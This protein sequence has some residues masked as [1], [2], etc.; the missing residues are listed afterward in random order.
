MPELP[1][2]ETVRRGLQHGVQGARIAAVSVYDRRLR[3][4][5][6]A[7]FEAA[8]IGATVQD[9]ERRS[10]YLLFRLDSGRTWL[11]HLGM[12]GSFVL[13]RGPARPARR[14]HDHV[15]VTLHT[16]EGLA[17][18]RYNDPRRFGSMHVFDGRDDAQPLLA[19]LGPEPLTDAFN[20]DY[21]HAATRRR[22][23]PI[24]QALMDNRLVVGVGNIY[25]NESLFRAGIHP[26][27]A[28][29]RV[30]RERL[31]RLVLE[32]KA[33]LHEAIAAGGSTLRDFVNSA[34]E[35]GYFQLDYN[36]YGRDGQPC[37]RCGRPLKPMR[38]GGRATVYCAHCQR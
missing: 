7:D 13:H 25:A 26:D 21:L 11:A 19:A 31:A 18:L 33:V 6:A 24:K 34:G 2:V 12:T 5:V 29:N 22:S 30:S 23:G 36:V 20:A 27:R 9:I 17:L 10:K 8:L 38:H 16:P 37:R 15:D 28:V 4:P 35:P 14:T 1:E 3:W 32:V